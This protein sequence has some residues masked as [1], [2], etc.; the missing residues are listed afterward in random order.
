MW[1]GF[2]LKKLLTSRNKFLRKTTS[3][4]HNIH[5]IMLELL[6]PI[7]AYCILEH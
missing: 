3:S 2:L 1:N 4:T 5:A 7:P 6:E